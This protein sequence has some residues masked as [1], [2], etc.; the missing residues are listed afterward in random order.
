M[1][2]EP[3]AC[4]SYIINQILD[5]FEVRSWDSEPQEALSEEDEEDKGKVSNEKI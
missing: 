5:E 3:K 4:S 1:K 2:P